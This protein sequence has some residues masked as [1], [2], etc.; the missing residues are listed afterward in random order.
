MFPK[1]SSLLVQ[2]VSHLTVGEA[3][4]LQEILANISTAAGDGKAKKL[5]K[6]LDG[7]TKEQRILALFANLERDKSSL[8]LC[9]KTIDS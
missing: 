8:A 7:V 1:S 6:A 2:P 3:K 5:W 9:I 4:K